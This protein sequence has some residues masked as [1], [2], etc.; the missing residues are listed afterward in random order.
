ME[1]EQIAEVCHEANRIYCATQGDFSHKNWKE[2]SWSLKQSAIAGVVF[3]QENHEASLGALHEQWRENRKVQ[4]WVYGE[5]KDEAT[6]THPCMRPYEDLPAMQKA[7]DALFRSIV[8]ALT[9]GDT[10]E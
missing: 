7:K 8:K 1:V 9:P 6:K 2:T 5:I 10:H 3:L 4:G